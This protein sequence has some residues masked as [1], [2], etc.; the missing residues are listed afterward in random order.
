MCERNI[1]NNGKK[2]NPYKLETSSIGR[3][4]KPT[5][6]VNSLLDSMRDGNEYGSIVDASPPAELDLFDEIIKGLEAIENIRHHPC[7]VYAGNVV[8]RDSGDQGSRVILPF[9]VSPTTS[10]L[11]QYRFD[12]S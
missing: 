9:L 6:I 11:E 7:L 12:R 1:A 5:K 10:S 8:R 3:K 4:A 2:E